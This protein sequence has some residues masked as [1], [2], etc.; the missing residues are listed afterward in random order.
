MN[1]RAV[2]SLAV[3]SI[4]ASPATLAEPFNERGEN[5]IGNVKISLHTKR[6]PVIVEFG[7]FNERGENFNVTAP[8]GTY[9]RYAPVVAESN[10]FNERGED[11]I[12]RI[13]LDSVAD[14]PSASISSVGFDD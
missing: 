10:S 7:S 12:G 9:N 8:A 11:F 13:R 1:M 5:F 4:L 3:I 14:F 2:L 6:Q